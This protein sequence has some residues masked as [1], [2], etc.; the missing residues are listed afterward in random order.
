M[1]VKKKLREIALTQPKQ[2]QTLVENRRIFNLRHC[3]LNVFES[4][5]QAYRVPLTFN[6]LVI[7]SMV[8]GKKVMHLPGR[9]AFDY[10]PGETVI[11]RAG[12]TM[13]IDFPLAEPASP[14]QCVALTVDAD[15]VH[16]T[17]HYLEEYYNSVPDERSEWKLEFSQYHFDNEAD[18]AALMNRLIRICSGTEAAKNIYA[19]LNLKELLIRIMQSQHLRLLIQEKGN[20]SNENRIHFVLNYI[21]EHLTERIPVDLLSRKAYLSRNI[22]FK[23]FKE[24]L[25]ITPLEYINRE[26]LKF[27]KQLL[28]DGKLSVGDVGL[29]CGFNDTNYFVRLFRKSEGITP[30]AYQELCKV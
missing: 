26:R 18:V 1:P 15:Y 20:N 11:A 22:F 29:Q 28:S 5:Q 6:D 13:I 8:R 2:L 19:D 12:D 14:T 7:T 21:H 25:G 17:L 23:W 3:E 16:D 9:E 4:Y 24:Q 30:G 10:L 27:A